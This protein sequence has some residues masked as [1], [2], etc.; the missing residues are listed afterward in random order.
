[1]TPLFDYAEAFSRNIGWITETEQHLLRGKRVAIAGMGGVGGV[2]LLTLARLGVG[3]FY[4]A[5]LDTF[6]LANFNRQAGAMVSTLGQPKVEVLARQAQDINPELELQLFPAG[7]NADNVDDFLRGVDLFVDGL[8]FFVPEVRSL[9]FGR[10]HALGIP[11]ITAGPIGM[12]APYLIFMP[13]GMSFE[14]YFRLENLPVERQYV[15]FLLGLTPKALHRGYLV[16]PGRLNL[17]GRHG[18]ST[19]MACQLCA[20]IVGIEALKILLHRR[21]VHA[22]PWYHLFDAYR[23]CYRRGKLR[24]GNGGPLQRLKCR[25]GYRQ[26]ERQLAQAGEL[27][28]MPEPAA[29]SVLEQIL[30]LAR[31]APSGDNSQPWRFAIHGEEEVHVYARTHVGEDVYEYNDAQPTQLSIGCLLET[32]RIAA[33]AWG[34]GLRWKHQRSGPHEHRVIVRLPQEEVCRDALFD[35]IRLR[36]VDRR[37]YQIISLSPAHKQQLAGCLGEELKLYWRE[38]PDE[39]WRMARLTALASDIRLRI[40]EAFAVHQRI[41]DWRNGNSPDGI[42]AAAVGLDLVTLRLMRGVMQGSWQQADFINRYLGG[43]LM[44]RIELDLLPGFCCA[45]HFI[46]ARAERKP[47]LDSESEFLLRAG[48]HIQRFW[49]EATRLGLVMQPAVAPLCFAYY[50][51]HEILFTAHPTIRRKAALLA[52]RLRDTASGEDADSI[53]FMGRLGFPAFTGVQPRSIRKPL[54]QL[55]QDIDK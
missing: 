3:K 4:I 42:P 43:T 27:R 48:Q 36:S 2:H 10:C 13:G 15:N 34:R 30:D 38:T 54:A 50:G 5:D 21:P 6:E 45:A 53:L 29:G 41:M 28:S 9:V 32:L 17:A 24:W 1:M 14:R 16:E 11:A 49:L 46:I 44:P 47:R 22:A 12:G 33:S 40:P 31:W 18:P 39:R 26:V 25:I 7:V 52:E 8:D 55:I 19:A 37:R 23:G 20:G 51:Q 35:F